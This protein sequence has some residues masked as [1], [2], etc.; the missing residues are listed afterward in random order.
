MVRATTTVVDAV[1]GITAAADGTVS[2][3]NETATSMTAIMGKARGRAT[4]VVQLRP[5]TEP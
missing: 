3:V 5:L 4:T 1:D 2:T